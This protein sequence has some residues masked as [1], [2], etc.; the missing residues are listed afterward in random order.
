MKVSQ[1]SKIIFLSAV[2][3]VVGSALFFIGYIGYDSLWPPNIVEFYDQNG[4]TTNL[5]PLAREYMTDKSLIPTFYPGDIVPLRFKGYKY[6]D[7]VPQIITKLVDGYKKEL[8]E[9]HDAKEIG[10]FDKPGLSR[11]IPMDAISSTRP[12]YLEITYIYDRNFFRKGEK[13]VVR[14]EPFNIVAPVHNDKTDTELIKRI[15]SEM[16]RRGYLK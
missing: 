4:N 2:G 9:V 13:Y 11:K 14:S 3:F 6:T 5:I 16:K 7:D 8:E 10:P 15:I 12:C 1:L